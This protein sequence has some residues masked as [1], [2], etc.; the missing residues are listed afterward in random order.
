M[1]DAVVSRVAEAVEAARRLVALRKA[2]GSYDAEERALRPY[3]RLLHHLKT[4]ARPN[5]ALLESLADARTDAQAGRLILEA[6][7]PSVTPRT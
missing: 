2:G 7:V 3:P 1:D 5:L 6:H 4:A